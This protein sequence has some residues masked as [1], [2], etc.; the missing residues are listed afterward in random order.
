VSRRVSPT[1]RI[2]AEIDVLFAS[3]R[4]LASS[5]E[6]VARL[7]VRVMMQTALEAEL[8]EILGPAATSAAPMSTRRARGWGPLGSSRGHARGDLMTASGRTQRPLTPTRLGHLALS[9]QLRQ[10]GVM[11]AGSA[12]FSIAAARLPVACRSRQG[13]RR[14]AC[15]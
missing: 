7:T 8:D 5:L 12:P 9:A 1:E 10:P 3:D 13:A 15:R 14:L 4:D 2:R 6:D 11:T